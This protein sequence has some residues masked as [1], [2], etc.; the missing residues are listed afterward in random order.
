MGLNYREISQNLTVSVS[1]VAR[2]V[3]RFE[4]TGEVRGKRLSAI[5]ALTVSQLL[6]YVLHEQNA[7]FDSVTDV[8]AGVET[9]DMC[10]LISMLYFLCVHAGWDFVVYHDNLQ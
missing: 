10:N 4:R 5:A 7:E 8:L 6:C 3:N 2:I 9:V 1:T